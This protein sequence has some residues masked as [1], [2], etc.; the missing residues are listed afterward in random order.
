MSGAVVSTL[1]ESLMTEHELQ[2]VAGS[3]WGNFSA[4]SESVEQMLQN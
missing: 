3:S 4:V 1:S 2:I